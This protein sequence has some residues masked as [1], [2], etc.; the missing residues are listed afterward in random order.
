MLDAALA[1]LEQADWTP[2]AIEQ[3][4]R[5]AGAD[6]GFVN[7]EGHVQ[8]A[9]AQAPVRVALTGRRVGP[10]LWESTAVLGRDRAVARLRSARARIAA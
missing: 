4:I 1:R 9:K 8:L 7:D 5:A 2:E 10:P 3:A 6:A